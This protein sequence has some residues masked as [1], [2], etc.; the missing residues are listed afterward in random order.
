MPLFLDFETA[1]DA[2]LEAVSSWN[3]SRHPSTEVLC[4]AFDIADSP[5]SPVSRFQWFPGQELPE[6]VLRFLQGN[7]GIVVHNASFEGAILANCRSVRSWPKVILDRFI[8]TSLMARA[9]NLPGSLEGLGAA[10]SLPIKKDMEGNALTKMLCTP[11]AW[12]AATREQKQ[13]VFAYNVQDVEVM[14]LA[15]WRLPPMTVAEREAAIADAEINRRG[16]PV[17]LKRSAQLARLAEKRKR[18]I[19]EEAFEEAGA[20]TVKVLGTARLKAWLTSQGVALP[21]KLKIDKET[22]N[23][24]FVESIDKEG[25]KKLLADPGL[26]PTVRSVLLYRA[27]HGKVGALAKLKRIPDLIS[28][29]GRLRN[30]LRFCAAHTGRWASYGVQVHNLAKNKLKTK[31]FDYTPHVEELVNTGNIEMMRLIYDAPLE[32]M[33]S[34]LRSLFVASPGR[35]LIGADYAAIEA[36]GIAW[37]AG[38]QD[39][40]DVFASGED[41]Y[42]RDAAGVGSDNRQLGKTLRLG[43]GYGMGALKFILTAAKDGIVVARKDAARMVKLWRQNNEAIVDFWHD[44]ERAAHDAVENMGTVYQVRNI[45]MSATK[46][47]LSVKL[48]S[49]RVIRY[50]R[51]KVAVVKKTIETLT[52]EG[53]IKRIEREGPELQ[54]FAPDEETGQFVKQSTYGGKLAENLTQAVCRDLLAAATVR[55]RGTLYETVLHV[56]DSIAAEVPAGAGDRR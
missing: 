3:Y 37:L 39:V 8:D 43:L 55:L 22:G 42:V 36:R 41:I 49:G 47:C 53:E 23:K 7:G 40:L 52:D 24:S 19:E 44:I 50:W 48:P 27:E 51:P 10:L 6:L 2:D 30:A 5:T 18:Q 32:V 20:D 34:L 11:A 17:D 13:R 45:T 28:D 25:L 9:A 21:K 54:F 4:A 35:E 46:A 12:V 15:F 31:T 56:H 14:R 33:M 16:V 1:S 38:Q 29:D 26:D